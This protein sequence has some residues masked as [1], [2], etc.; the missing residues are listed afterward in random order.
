[1]LYTTV[2]DVATRLGRP[3]SGPEEAQVGAWIQDVEETIRARIVDLDDRVIEGVPPFGIVTKVVAGAV[4]RKLHN[5]DGLTS[6][7]VSVD[8]GS[9]TTRRD[10]YRGGD[11]LSLTDEE[12]AELMPASASGAWS[13]RPGFVAE[14]PVCWWVQ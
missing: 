12:W 5:P 1:M 3:L 6:K 14:P 4:L 11:P 7:T 9:V 2:S 13:V 8:D 10:G